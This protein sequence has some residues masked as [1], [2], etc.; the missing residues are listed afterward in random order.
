MLF[1][2]NAGGVYNVNCEVDS[3][4]IVYIVI[5]LLHNM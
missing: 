4:T 3:C 5:H 2:Y 1:A